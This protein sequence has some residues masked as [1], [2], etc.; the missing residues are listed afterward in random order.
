MTGFPSSG[1]ALCKSPLDSP[2]PCRWRIIIMEWGA[3]KK[4]NERDFPAVKADLL[5]Y[6][7]LSV[8]AD[9][10]GFLFN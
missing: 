4:S 2:D 7:H 9:M 5:L 1:E 8:V 6:Q 10:N 3:I